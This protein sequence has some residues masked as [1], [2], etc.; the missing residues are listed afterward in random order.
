MELPRFEEI[1]WTVGLVHAVNQWQRPLPLLPC[2]SEAGM[3]ESFTSL[4]LI[5]YNDQSFH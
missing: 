1:T 3:L 2:P 4:C 5:H